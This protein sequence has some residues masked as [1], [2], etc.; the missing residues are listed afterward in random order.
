ML[1]ADRRTEI[2]ATLVVASSPPDETGHQIA[3]LTSLAGYQLVV[4]PRVVLH[5][6]YWDL[7]DGRLG[8]QHVA[9]RTR[10]TD[11]ER[12][13]TLKGRA[14]GFRTV[15]VERLEIEEPWSKPALADVLQALESL[16]LAP[17]IPDG[18]AWSKTPDESLRKLGFTVLQERET[19]RRPRDA[20]PRDL[21]E[22]VSVAE[23]AI[24]TTTYRLGRAVVRH[25]EVEIEARGDRGAA[26]LE[27][28]VDA[29]LAR[30]PS[31][32]RPWH[33]SKL[34]TGKAAAALLETGLLNRFLSENGDIEPP[35]YDMIADYLAKEEPGLPDAQGT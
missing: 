23:L 21:P 18:S 11:R 14:R 22:P 30:F 24:D 3:A 33:H 13:L 17:D 19:I 29:L 4:R 27:P 25:H 10:S 31:Q 1:A 7:P 26:A 2:E 6:V 28:M 15:G 35:A 12:L 32:L 34:V 8:V 16:G 5:D 9:L 20:I